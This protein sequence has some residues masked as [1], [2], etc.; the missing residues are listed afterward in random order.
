M[1]PLRALLE[2]LPLERLPRTG[3]VQAGIAEPESVAAHTVGS[4]AVVLAL[5]PA[6][7]PPLDLDRALALAFVHDLPEALLGDLP[8]A[9]AEL[10]PPGAKATAEARAARRLLEPL[11]GLALARH[12]EFTDQRT[13]EA[14]FARACERLHLGVR[15]VGYHRAGHRGLASFADTIARLDV[16]EFP[17]CAALQA[18]ILG[19]LGQ[20][21]PSL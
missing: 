5:G 11:S 13:R 2:L 7:D 10:L 4:C 18:E 6:V 21:P 20:S 19:A 15:L 1:S 16:S 14:R 3:W 12:G 17:P 9:A 8:R